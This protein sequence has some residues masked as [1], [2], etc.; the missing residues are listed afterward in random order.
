M[1]T[2][3][4][5]ALKSTLNEENSHPKQPEL[6][7]DI[8]LVMMVRPIFKP[9]NWNTLKAGTGTGAGTETETETETGRNSPAGLCTAARA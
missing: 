4:L 3:D 1:E 7:A 8:M 2:T 5:E 6:A 9:G